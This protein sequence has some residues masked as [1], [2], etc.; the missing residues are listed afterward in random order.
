MLQ[1]VDTSLRPSPHTRCPPPPKPLTPAHTLH[2]HPTP[3]VGV[4]I[5]PPY[6][7]WSIQRQGPGHLTLA[8]NT[9]NARR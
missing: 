9:G 5:A 1:E 6:R 7:S 4:A 3:S 8:R 2:T